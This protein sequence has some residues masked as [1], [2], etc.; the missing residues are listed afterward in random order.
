MR[1]AK[2]ISVFLENK[3]GTLGNMCDQLSAQEINIMALSVGDTADYAVVRLVVDN[4][5]DA[6]HLLEEAGAIVVENEVLL[7][8]LENRIGALG[9][10][11]D[12]LSEADINI[13]Y[14]Y[15]AVGPD[16]PGGLI[17]L[18]VSDSQ[19]AMHVLS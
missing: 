19:K 15:C 6:T 12:Q 1:L 3:P 11:A 7:V 17:V 16:K 10:L 4:P 13:E 18:R 5:D 9:D 8:E 14:A 2:Q